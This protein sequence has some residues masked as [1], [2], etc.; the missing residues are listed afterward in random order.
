LLLR[1]DENTI[2]S[3][4]SPGNEKNRHMKIPVHKDA[5]E[6]FEKNDNDHKFI[7]NNIVGMVEII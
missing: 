3:A 4:K 2:A 1:E 6:A 7:S 5:S